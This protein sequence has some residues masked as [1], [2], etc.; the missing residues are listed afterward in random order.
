MPLKLTSLP[1]LRKQ[2]QKT[3]ASLKKGGR[4]SFYVIGSESSGPSGFIRSE[5]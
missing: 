2:P 4:G 1:M 3:P 5:P